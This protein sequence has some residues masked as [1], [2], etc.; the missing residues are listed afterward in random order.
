MGINQFFSKYVKYFFFVIFI[1]V[2]VHPVAL[3]Y[4]NFYKRAVN[5]NWNVFYLLQSHSPHHRKMTDV[6]STWR[7]AETYCD[8]WD[9]I[10]KKHF[11]C[12]WQQVY[13]NCIAW[14]VPECTASRSRASQTH[15]LTLTFE[16]YS[17]KLII[18][19]AN[20]LRSC[21]SCYVSTP[22]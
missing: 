1:F 22:Y 15:H 3:N 9:C 18:Y 20:K 10:N 21:P 11:S 12:D 5:R 8:E 4:Y 14:N 16:K 2:G 7:W 19:D 17:Q 13:R 6:S